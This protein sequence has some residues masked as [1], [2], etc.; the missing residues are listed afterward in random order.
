MMKQLPSFDNA[1]KAIRGGKDPRA[2]L[3]L[4]ILYAQGIGT[5][6]DEI[7]AQY[8]IKKALDM[9]CKEAEKYLDFGYESGAKDFGDEINTFIENSNDISRET[10]T[11]LRMRIEK[12]RMAGNIG[13]LAKIRKHFQ[14]FYPEYNREKAISD[15]LNNRHTVD[16]DILFAL[17]TADNRSE[18]YLELQDRLL[19]QLYAPITSVTKVYD[20]IIKADDTNLLGKDESELAQCIVNLTSSYGAICKKYGIKPQYIFSLDSLGLYPYIRVFDLAT[21]RRQGFKALLSIKDVEATIRDKFLECLDSDEKLLNVCE[22]VKNQDIQLFLI[23]FVE[24]N[25]DIESLEINS[26]S[27]LKAYRNK[28]LEPLAK[29]INAFIYRLN[30]AGIEN[31][32]PYYSS[33]FLPPIDLSIGP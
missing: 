23:S 14:L 16:A 1:Q 32:L 29:H 13:N 24:L 9:G 20:D 15:I 30:K 2:F 22:E 8:F 6:Q 25:I 19:Q 7:L 26:L 4:G 17:S 5:S 21:L 3:H 12:E 31:H 33:G 18:V 28:D 10:I 11:K 27:L